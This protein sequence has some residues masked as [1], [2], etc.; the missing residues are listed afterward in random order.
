MQG[1]IPG[2]NHLPEMGESVLIVLIVLIVIFINYCRSPGFKGRD[3][4]ME[5]SLVPQ[6]NSPGSGFGMGMR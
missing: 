1:R 2:W 6:L 4:I 5:M 3:G